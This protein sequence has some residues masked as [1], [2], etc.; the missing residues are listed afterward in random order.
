M[1]QSQLIED[2]KR[3]TNDNLSFAK[4]LLKLDNSKLIKS[5]NEN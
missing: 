2:L 4:E 3:M 5:K 1:K